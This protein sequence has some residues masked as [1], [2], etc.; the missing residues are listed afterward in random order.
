MKLVL[1]TEIYNLKRILSRIQTENR[2]TYVRYISFKFNVLLLVN[3]DSMY[4]Y[5]INDG[6]CRNQKSYYYVKSSP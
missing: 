1:P 2:N 3:L 6:E 5:H 4:N